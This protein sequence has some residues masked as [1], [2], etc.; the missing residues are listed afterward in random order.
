MTAPR[1]LTSYIKNVG[2][3]PVVCARPWA[4]PDAMG[5]PGEDAVAAML[6]GNRLAIASDDFT[7]ACAAAHE[8]LELHHGFEHSE[9]LFADQAELMGAW[10]ADMGKQFIDGDRSMCALV[11]RVYGLARAGG[12]SRIVAAIEDGVPDWVLRG[13]Q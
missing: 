3:Q 6:L 12:C 1:T 13:W 10:L 4:H 11:R 2:F 7:S 5:N 9:A 8:I